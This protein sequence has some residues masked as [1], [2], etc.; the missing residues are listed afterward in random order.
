[1]GIV[2]WFVGGAVLLIW[3]LSLLIV[4][5]CSPPPQPLPSAHVHKNKKNALLVIAHPDD[6]SMFFAPTLLSL[7]SLGCYHVRILCLSNG[8]AEGLGAIRKQEMLSACSFLKVPMEDVDVL[9][10][11]VLQDGHKKIWSQELISQILSRTV[12]KHN[13]DMIITF[14]KYGVSGHANHI[15]VHG[16]VCRFLWNCA[17][18][19]QNNLS[20]EAWKL[21]S[22]NIIQ[23]YSGPIYVLWSMWSNKNTN[24]SHHFYSKSPRHST[25]AMRLHA[26]QWLWYRRMFVIFSHYTYMNT[27]HKIQL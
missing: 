2:L 16:G 9:D 12:T 14:D 5:A 26:T 8:N 17:R 3:L 13:I 27:L 18:N 19:S 20:V 1:M 11:P 24:Q 4:L 7:A 10:D 25:A 15:A 23:K 6:E 22:V 21:E